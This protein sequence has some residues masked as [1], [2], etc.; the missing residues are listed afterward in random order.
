MKIELAGLELRGFHGVEED[1]RRHGQRF[2]F[3]IV[4]EVGE[5]GVSDRIE[6]AVDYRDVA[7]TVAQV[8][9]RQFQLLEAFATAIADA[10][11]ERFR[12]ESLSVRV[13]KPQVR[14]AGFSV[15]YSAVTVVRP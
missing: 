12:P 10:L 15:E 7:R 11:E 13:R 9:E 2:L 5:R 4:L 6:D 3:D 14:P 8:N 1:E